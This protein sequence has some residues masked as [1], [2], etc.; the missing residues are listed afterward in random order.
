MAVELS[1]NAIVHP[2][3]EIGDGCTIGPFCTVG[4]NVQVGKNTTLVSHVVVG[5]HTTIGEDCRIYPFVSLGLQSQ[6]LKYKEGSVTYTE[7]GDRNIIREYV[8]VH[9]GTEEGST[10]RVGSDCALLAQSHIAHNCDVGDHVVLSHAATLGGHVTVGDYANL[11]GLCAVHQMC[12]VGEAAMVA[13]MAR[14][15]QDVLAFTIAE[16]FPARMRVV[17]R[18]GME[19]AGYSKRAIRDVRE[20]FKILF[21]RNLRLEEAVKVVRQKLG[22]Q[23]HVEQMLEGIGRS[24][25]GLARQDVEAFEQNVG[26]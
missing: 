12:C 6:D 7:I 11:G 22:D 9:S 15:A 20:A 26:G 10:T 25:K 1:S 17:N 3:A 13:G 16:G 21:L 24:Q 8:S 19:R 18:I 14:L 4:E 23:D 2:K 5:D